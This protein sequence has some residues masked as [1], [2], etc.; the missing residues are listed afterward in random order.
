MFRKATHIFTQSIMRDRH[1]VQGVQ[2]DFHAL[3]PK[4]RIQTRTGQRGLMRQ[5]AEAYQRHHDSTPIVVSKVS[6]VADRLSL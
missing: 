3:D 2:H 4:H 1:D 5:N 6:T